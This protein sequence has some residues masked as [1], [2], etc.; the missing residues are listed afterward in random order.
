MLSLLL[1][2]QRGL[3][4]GCTAHRRAEA[5]PFPA[6]TILLPCLMYYIVSSSLDDERAPT[7]LYS[8]R[9]GE[10]PRYDGKATRLRGGAP[11]GDRI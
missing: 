9:W 3:G 2:P 4:V 5:I 11:D 1:T 10:R 6:E 8:M 7:S